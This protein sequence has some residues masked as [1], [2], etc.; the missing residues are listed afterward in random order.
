[1]PRP[2]SAQLYFGRSCMCSSCS[3]AVPRRLCRIPPAGPCAPCPAGSPGGLLTPGPVSTHD[4]CLWLPQRMAGSPPTQTCKCSCLCSGLAGWLA[5]WAVRPAGWLAARPA[6]WLAVQ[7]AGRLAAAGLPGLC[8]PAGPAVW[9]AG[10][11]FGRPAGWLFGRPAGWLF[12]R[13]AGLAAS[14][15]PAGWA[16]RPAGGRCSAGWRLYVCLPRAIEQIGGCRCVFS[17]PRCLLCIICCSAVCQQ[18]PICHLSPAFDC[19]V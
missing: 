12:G 2:A 6:G 11:L 13:P 18:G 5:G 14:G 1:M 15:R 16:V 8:V 3:A 19:Q 7:P 9:P 17:L 4:W 10:W